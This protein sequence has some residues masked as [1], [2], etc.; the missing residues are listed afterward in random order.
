MG[1]TAA[2]LRAQAGCVLEFEQFGQSYRIPCAVAALLP[3]SAAYQVTYWHNHMFNA[4]M[5]G[6][7]QILAFTPDWRQATAVPPI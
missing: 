7:V 6:A 1:G 4:A 3:D 2:A 5:P